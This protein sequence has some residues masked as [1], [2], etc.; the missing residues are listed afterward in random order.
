MIDQWQQHIDLEDEWEKPHDR[1][2]VDE[3]KILAYT[4]GAEHELHHCKRPARSRRI[5][6]TQQIK[7][8]VNHRVSRED[9]PKTMPQ[10]IP[11]PSGVFNRGSRKANVRNPQRVLESSA[12]SLKTPE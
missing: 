8:S 5:N 10:K 4:Y 9:R 6:K 12:A 1:R 11:V 7:A 2:F 3:P